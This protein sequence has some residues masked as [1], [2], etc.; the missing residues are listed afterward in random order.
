MKRQIQK[1][2]GKNCKGGYK[3]KSVAPG[4][5][6]HPPARRKR[7]KIVSPQLQAVPPRGGKKKQKVLF[8]R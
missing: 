1:K 8:S 7:K 3:N 6:P 4:R 5:F 2:K